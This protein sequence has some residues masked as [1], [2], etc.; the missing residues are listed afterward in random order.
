MQNVLNYLSVNN[1]RKKSLVLEVGYVCGCSVIPLTWLD[2]VSVANE[3]EEY[4]SGA[5]F[6]SVAAE[7]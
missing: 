5:I 7:S 4:L 1:G 6:A 2:A 3:A